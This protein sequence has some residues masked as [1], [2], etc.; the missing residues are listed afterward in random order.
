MKH[1]WEELMKRFQRL[2]LSS[3]MPPQAQK[4]AKLEFELQ[5]LEKD[6]A[7]IEQYPHIYVYDDNNA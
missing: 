3:D 5:Q 7:I 1:N 4:K 6:I 2:P